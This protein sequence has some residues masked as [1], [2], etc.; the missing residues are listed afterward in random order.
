[1]GRAVTRSL[2]LRVIAKPIIRSS[3]TT[4]VIAISAFARLWRKFG[5]PTDSLATPDLGHCAGTTSRSAKQG[6]CG[7]L[8]SPPS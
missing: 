7:F 2:F 6:S 8:F 5:F 1:M 3:N 4:I